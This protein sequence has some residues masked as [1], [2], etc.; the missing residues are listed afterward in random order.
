[1][2]R[3]PERVVSTKAGEVILRACEGTDAECYSDFWTAVSRETTHT[4]QTPSVPPPDR[5]SLVR[6]WGETAESARDLRIGIFSSGSQQ[7][8]LLGLLGFYVQRD[9]PWTRH[10]GTFGM[11]VRREAWGRGFGRLLLETMEF[12]AR[13]SGFLKIEAQVRVENSRGLEFYTRAGY[14]IEGR[15]TRAALIEGAFQ[16]EFYIAKD[17]DDATRGP[18]GF[19]SAEG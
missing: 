4:L 3:I 11:M 2:A 6:S 7:V 19:S 5:E 12:H 18:A 16:D 15:R 17:L 9:H 14:R 1:M 10:I 13:A 8:R